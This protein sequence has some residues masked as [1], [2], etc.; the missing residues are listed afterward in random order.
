MHRS[1]AA[2]LMLRIPELEPVLDSLATHFGEQLG[3]SIPLPAD[4]PAAY[5]LKQNSPAAPAHGQA[6]CE[7]RESALD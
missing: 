3:S 1:D 7:W 2:A 5:Q 6:V 4:L